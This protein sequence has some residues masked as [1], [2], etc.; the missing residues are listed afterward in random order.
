MTAAM[1]I[2]A[3]AFQ[4]NLAGFSADVEVDGRKETRTIRSLG[5]I[6]EATG[7]L[8]PDDVIAE[9]LAKRPKA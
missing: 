3:L 7:G 5:Q 1:L 6:R 8:H 4:Q 2:N 9:W